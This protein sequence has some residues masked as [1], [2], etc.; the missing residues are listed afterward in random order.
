MTKKAT[1]SKRLFVALKPIHYRA[2]CESGRRA[3]YPH[4]TDPTGPE[5]ERFDLDHLSDIDIQILL[6]TKTVAE[7]TEQVSED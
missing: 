2:F 7:V 6:T 4:E 5:A 1:K 3:I